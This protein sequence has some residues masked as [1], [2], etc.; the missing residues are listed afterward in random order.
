M[1]ATMSVVWYGLSAGQVHKFAHV[2][3]TN[4]DWHFC[5]ATKG[6]SSLALIFILFAKRPASLK[7]ASRDCRSDERANVIERSIEIL[8]SPIAIKVRTTRTQ[9]SNTVWAR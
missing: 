9:R 2:D 1:W 5:D 6:P 7:L 8:N 3:Q 4:V